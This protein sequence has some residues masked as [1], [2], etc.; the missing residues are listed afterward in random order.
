MVEYK[1]LLVKT[2]LDI[3]LNFHTTLTNFELI[4][5]TYMLSFSIILLLLE[6]VHTLIK[7][8]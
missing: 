6:M 4:L 7:F 1:I 3:A 8:S 2:G 5:F